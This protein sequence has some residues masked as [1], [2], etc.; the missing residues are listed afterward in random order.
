MNHA[1]HSVTRKPARAY[2]LALWSLLALSL[3]ANAQSVF[4]TQT[5]AWPDVTDGVAYELGMKFRAT[6]AGTVSAIRFWKAASDT[7]AHTGT[8]WSAAG[9]ALASV[10]F[11]G[12]TASGW[13]QQALAAPLAVQANTVYVVSVSTTSR[14][15]MTSGGLSAAVVSGDLSSVADGANG[16]FGSA[17]AFPTGSWNNGNYFRDIVYEA[18]PAPSME[19]A[20]GNNQTGTVATALASPL[21]V[22]VTNAAGQAQSGTTVTFSVLEGGGSVSTANVVTGANG[23]ASVT[24]TLGNLVG[25][26]RV[27]A[28]STGIG[29]IEFIAT[30]TGAVP[31]SGQTVHTT[32]VPALANAQIFGTGY[33]LGM[34]FSAARP[35]NI[36]GIRFWKPAGETGTHVGKIWTVGGTLLA[37][38]TF[39]GE[40]ASGWQQ[41][42]LPA[43]LHIN[44]STTYMVSVN[45][46]SF[47]PFTGSGLAAP[48][49]N[50]DLSSI[51]DGSNGVY[52]TPGLFPTSTFQNADYFRDVAYQ[53]DLIPSIRK[54][55]GDN[56]GG[57]VGSPLPQPLVVQV[58]DGNNNPKAG[59]TVN[60]AVTTGAGTVA[61]VNAVTDVNGNAS[62]TLTLGNAGGNTK[63]TATS[64]NVGSVVF[65]EVAGNEIFFENQKAGT[66]DFL[67]LLSIRYTTSVISG[68]ADKQSVNKGGTIN[69]KVSTDQPGQYAIDFYRLG[70]YGGAGGRLVVSSGA[71]NG[72]TQQTCSVTRPSTSLLECKWN[73][74]FTLNVPSTWVSGIYMAKLVHFATLKEHPVY[75][76]VRDDGKPS[77][78]LFQNSRSDM[79]AYNGWGTATDHYSLYNYNSTNFVRALQVSLDRPSAE[80][81]DYNDILK[82]EFPMAYWLESQGYDVTYTTNFDVHTNPERLLTHKMFMSVGH[83]EYWTDQMRNG[84]EAARDAGVNIAFFSAN[85]AYWRVRLEPSTTGVPN[86]VMTCYK[87]PDITPDPVSPPTYRWRDPGN[88]R[89][90]NALLGV[91]YIGDH[92]DVMGGFDHTVTNATD[93]YYANTGLINGSKLSKLVGYEWDA[94]VNNGFTPAG[95]KILGNST[96]VPTEIAPGIPS[97]ATQ[98]ANAV[99][100]TAASGA[101]VFSAGSIQWMWGLYTPFSVTPSRVDPKAQ[102]FATNVLSDM[103]AKPVSPSPGI[104]LP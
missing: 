19:I 87:L 83:D 95:L 35:G 73:N 75:F 70:Y 89:P 84:V 18:T 44:G 36:A 57:S 61:P 51:A 1:L 13:Q 49:V 4:T 28:T 3:C 92:G 33:E 68:Y 43:P 8:I 47:Y 17:G 2:S 38:A 96:V 104:I 50:G 101:K 53:A 77:Q 56:Q 81:A 94:V 9:A 15:A 58:R 67:I 90:E 20:S 10:N 86:R 71:L 98:Q 79:L 52:G 23:Q 29:S 99:K 45:A 78:I 40:T 59:A 21:V 103:G 66:S 63:V 85:T 30:A 14:F 102:Q 91:M 88:N 31:V 82:Y 5:P 65:S 42:N 32:Q 64:P 39:A 27:Q 48:I 26:N 41:Q 76:I 97:T 74:S 69:F 22:S 11:T 16:V 46:V 80:G 12:E 7:G 62:T 6:R 72:L 54:I 93:P 24:W 55:S 100:Y 60:F 25:T 37:S 34:K